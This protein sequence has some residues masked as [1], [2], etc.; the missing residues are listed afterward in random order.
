MLE[1][2]FTADIHGNKLQYDKLFR[3]AQDYKCNIILGG[4]LLPNNIEAKEFIQTQKR[5][6]MNFL[7]PK[8]KEFK[9]KTGKRVYLI[10]GNDDAKINES[11]LI[12]ESDISYLSFRREKMSEFYIVGYSYIPITPFLIKDWEKYDLDFYSSCINKAY[13]ENLNNVLFYGIKSTEKGWK[14]FVFPKIVTESIEDDLHTR[15]FTA[16][17]DKT[18]YVIHSPP[19]NTSLDL[20]SI[21]HKGSFA[22]RDFIEKNKPL[23]TL[24][25]HMHE[26][27]KISGKYKETI[28]STVC[29]TS[30]NN[31]NSDKLSL[32]LM[33]DGLRDIERTLL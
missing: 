16:K 22:I 24:H 14:E 18:I 29:V 3:F 7:I 21:G 13:K 32:I 30:G 4:D 2:I 26:T 19:N 5:F 8:C 9:R 20:C 12:K 25:G 10:L 33:F 15:I 17:S 27:V 6:L 23:L 31:P 1:A 28:G 11:L